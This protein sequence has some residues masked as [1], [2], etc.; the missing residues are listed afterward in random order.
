MVI[1]RE[2]MLAWMVYLN[3]VTDDGEPEFQRRKLNSNQKQEVC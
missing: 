2:V 3:D 1:V